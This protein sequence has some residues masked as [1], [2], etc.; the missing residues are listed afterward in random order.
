MFI[1]NFEDISIHYHIRLILLQQ[2]SKEKKTE[3]FGDFEF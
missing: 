2:L 1:V 3:W